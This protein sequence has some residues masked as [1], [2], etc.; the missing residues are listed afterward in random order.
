MSLGFETKLP[1]SRVIRGLS[2]EHVDLRLNEGKEAI[3][4]WGREISDGNGRGNKS[5]KLL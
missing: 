2:E 5:G 3:E 1:L 4:F